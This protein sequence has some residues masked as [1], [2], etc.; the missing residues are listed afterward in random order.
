MR[1]TNIFLAFTLTALSMLSP[2]PTLAGSAPQSPREGAVSRQRRDDN[3][4]KRIDRFSL[5]L[6]V[7]LETA[8]AN[9]RASGKGQIEPTSRVYVPCPAED[10]FQDVLSVKVQVDG[11]PVNLMEVKEAGGRKLYAIHVDSLTSQS[12]AVTYDM[13]RYQVDK[14][15]K[16]KYTNRNLRPP[17]DEEFKFYTR[18]LGLGADKEDFKNLVASVGLQ[19]NANEGEYAYVSRLCR[20]FTARLNYRAEYFPVSNAVEFITKLRPEVDCI[21]SAQLIHSFLCAA[22]IPCRV[23][24]VVGIDES[25]QIRFHRVNY[26]WDS[27]RGWLPVDL[28]FFVA[29]QRQDIVDYL[30]RD[31]TFILLDYPRSAV[32]MGVDVLYRVMIPELKRSVTYPLAS[33]QNLFLLYSSGQVTFLVPKGSHTPLLVKSRD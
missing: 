11:S 32:D 10:E 22:Q 14:S 19:R 12:L 13:V 17:S 3:A 1:S 15:D 33:G 7:D 20:Y 2:A 26:F 16:V 27:Q 21:Y 29:S 18:D 6:T 24:S 23:N 28:S 25:N 31:S 9:I 5:T 30:G 4:I 8:L